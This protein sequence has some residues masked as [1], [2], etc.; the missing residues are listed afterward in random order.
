MI[1]NLKGRTIWKKARHMYWQTI[2]TMSNTFVR[3]LVSV[4]VLTHHGE[5][6]L[7]GHN[8]QNFGNTE[9][10]S[11]DPHL[12]DAEKR[13]NR[14]KNLCYTMLSYVFT[15]KSYFSSWLMML[16]WEM[17]QDFQALTKILETWNTRSTS[18]RFECSKEFD[19]SPP[20]WNTI[21]NL[22][23]SSPCR[24]MRTPNQKSHENHLTVW[25]AI[26]PTAIKQITPA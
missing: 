24:K 18:C 14:R 19:Q 12:T 20:V 2:D 6:C 5:A 26:H 16:A 3:A 1:P 4:G 11:R 21:S 22:I 10:K 23:A 7:F 8:I 17:W 13:A 25:T 15:D 9:I